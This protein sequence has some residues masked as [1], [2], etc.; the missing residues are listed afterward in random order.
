VEGDEL[1]EERDLTPDHQ[2]W[3]AERSEKIPSS[4]RA[5][6]VSRHRPSGLRVVGTAPDRRAG[7]MVIARLVSQRSR[8][9][10]RMDQGGDRDVCK[11][12]KDRDARHRLA[13]AWEVS[14]LPQ[15][16]RDIP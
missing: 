1:Q 10:D 13:E 11:G 16:V 12:R 2:L 5:A 15:L 3:E 4:L 6:P 8:A 7:R 14:F 9:E